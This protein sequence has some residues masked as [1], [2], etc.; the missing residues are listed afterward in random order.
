MTTKVKV[1]GRVGGASRLVRTRGDLAG[2][3]EQEFPYTLPAAE[4]SPRPPEEQFQSQQ[5]VP[6]EVIPA[7][8][9]PGNAVSPG[10]GPHVPQN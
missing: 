4:V 2:E 8:T 10:P 5:Q 6:Q 3:S 1:W 7:P 9:P